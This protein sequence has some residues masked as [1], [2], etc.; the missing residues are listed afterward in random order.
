MLLALLLLLL[1]RRLVRLLLRLGRLAVVLGIMALRHG[2]GSGSNRFSS[3]PWVHDP[4]VD[5]V[6]VFVVVVV[7]ELILVIIYCIVYQKLLLW[8]LSEKVR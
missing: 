7:V 4:P 5:V 6:G 2:D 8:L 1:Q 3:A